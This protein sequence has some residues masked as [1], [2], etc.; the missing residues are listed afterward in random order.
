MARNFERQN[1][2]E[3]TVDI[4]IMLCLNLVLCLQIMSGLFGFFFM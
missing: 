1:C 3:G 4:T 2:Y